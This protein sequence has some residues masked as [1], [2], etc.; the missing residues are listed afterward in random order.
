MAAKAY[1][2][3]ELTQKFRDQE[4]IRQYLM[5]IDSS[6]HQLH[7][8]ID[9]AQKAEPRI[10]K[11][12]EDESLSFA[13]KANPRVEKKV[14]ETAA[15]MVREG[16]LQPKPGK[17]ATTAIYQ[18]FLSASVLNDILYAGLSAKAIAA[19]ASNCIFNY[20]DPVKAFLRVKDYDY[21]MQKMMMAIPPDNIDYAK[22]PELTDEIEELDG[23]LSELTDLY[24]RPMSIIGL[25]HVEELE[26]YWKHF[27]ERILTSRT[28]LII[29]PQKVITQRLMKPSV[30]P[31]MATREKCVS[32]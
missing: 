10:R 31:I 28:I 14:E 9:D 15:R 21:S 13:F 11:I 8:I 32:C 24:T 30:G 27:A 5:S 17:S 29:P 19:I 25:H 7:H 18:A 26:N 4:E 23:E 12:S 22:S 2:L 1:S 3:I 16:L 6:A 20:R